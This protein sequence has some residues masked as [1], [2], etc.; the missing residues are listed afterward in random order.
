MSFNLDIPKIT[1]VLLP[2][3]IE[4]GDKLFIMGANGTGKSS[5]MQWVY[6]KYYSANTR[7]ISAHRQTWFTSNSI[8]YSPQQ[9]R[10]YENSI[11]NQDLN[12]ESRWRDDAGN[13]RISIMLYDLIDAE[14]IRNRAIAGAVDS[15]DMEGAKNLSKIDSVIKIINE[16]LSFSNIPIELLIHENEQLFARKC[17]GTSYSIAEL[18]DGERNALLIAAS[19][20][21]VK[22][23]SLLLIDEPERHLH[24]SIISPFLTY[25]FSKR[26]D[27][28]FIVSTHDMMLPLDNPSARTLL[29]RGC[30]HVGSSVTGWDI[31]IVSPE[32]Q[33]DD[34]IKKDIL[35]ARRKILFVEGKENSL[36]KPLY[37]LIFPNV[38]II[39]KSNCRDVEHTVSSIWASDHL[40]WVYACGIVDRDGR[41]DT[42][43]NRLREKH[44]YALLA[45]SVESIY[46]HPHIQDLIAQRQ[47]NLTGGDASTYLNNAKAA[48]IET[49]K[50]NDNIKH[51]SNRIAEKAVRKKFFSYLPKDTDI[52]NKEDIKVNIEVAKLVEQEYQRLEDDLNAGNLEKIIFRYPVRETPALNRIAKALEFPSCKQYEGAVRKLL[53]DDKEA[54][55]FVKTLFGDLVFDL[56]AA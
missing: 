41:P 44:V 14:N 12:L 9:R 56:E 7:W 47:A 11:R 35:G 27:C 42:D 26:K 24:R 8:N 3:S 55:T 52:Q 37:S 25:L 15:E 31:D 36:D 20:L 17:E 51:L 13:N 39:A 54:L 34:E 29:I 38:S 53:V 19:V 46:Y 22:P 10:D 28:A 18:S 33:I 48:A 1:G 5:L 21:T 30:T 50:L 23:G 45:F 2:I 32:T 4:A 40:H 6:K 43:I 49:L 16:L